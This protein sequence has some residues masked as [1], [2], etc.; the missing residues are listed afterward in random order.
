MPHVHAQRADSSLIAVFTAFSM[1]IHWDPTPQV[2]IES[3]FDDITDIDA[4]TQ[5][6]QT[7]HLPASLRGGS[8]LLSQAG[9]EVPLDLHGENYG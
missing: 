8:S 2:D 6:A 5:M 7:F 3:E 4:G 9:V 1:E